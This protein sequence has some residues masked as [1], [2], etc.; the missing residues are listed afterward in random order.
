[1]DDEQPDADPQKLSFDEYKMYYETTEKVTERRIATNRWDYSVCI[2][3]IVGIAVLVAWCSSRPTFFIF[4]TVSVVLFS[5]CGF[6]FCRYWL[7]EITAAKLLN[8]A[9][10]TVLNDMVKAVDF[11]GEGVTSY[12]P[13]AK[14]WELVVANEGARPAGGLGGRL[15]LSSSDAELFTPRVFSLVFAIIGVGAV[16][17]AIVAASVPGSRPYFPLSPEGPPAVQT[18]T[19]PAPSPTTTAVPAP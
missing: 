13:F 18:P 15:A 7:S 4:A 19:P 16:I 12:E 9:K 10:F 3:I 8:V 2:A 5:V 6:L 17:S 11:D 14:E 1:V